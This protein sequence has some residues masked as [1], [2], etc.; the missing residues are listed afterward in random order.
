[1]T[2]GSVGWN[3][4]RQRV[5]ERSWAQWIIDQAVQIHGG[6][7]YIVKNNNNVTRLGYLAWADA[8][9]AQEDEPRLLEHW[10]RAADEGRLRKMVPASGA[11][12]RMF[13]QLR[14]RADDSP[15]GDRARLER[16]AADVADPCESARTRVAFEDPDSISCL[17]QAEGR[18][19]AR[20]RGDDVSRA[21]VGR[22]SVAEVRFV[23]QE[24]TM[25]R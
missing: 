11:A 25:R 18:R 13:G 2:R 9:A 19:Q 10:R 6:Y 17:G 8:R 20:Q 7:G 14:Q 1:M 4:G 15:P 22:A 3:A 23:G 24:S 21:G 16:L 5:F 12:T